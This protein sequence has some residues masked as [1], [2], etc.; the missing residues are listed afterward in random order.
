MKRYL[1]SLAALALCGCAA[2]FRLV[3]RNN[4]PTIV[5]KSQNSYERQKGTACYTIVSFELMRPVQSGTITLEMPAQFG[6]VN[7]W[8]LFSNDGR[9][10]S[11][12]P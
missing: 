2:N 12:K 6:E 10:Y 1:L 8:I 4:P 3:N 9:M 7:D 5:A 11:T